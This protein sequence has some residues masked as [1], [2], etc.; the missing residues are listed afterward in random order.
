MIL[1]SDLFYRV[2]KHPTTLK[3][4]RE[5]PGGLVVRIQHFHY[6]G[7]GSIPGGGSEIPQGTQHGQ[8]KKNKK[9]KNNFKEKVKRE[10]I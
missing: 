5:F 3:E 10:Q 8:N 4:G 7:T 1:K 9:I 6:N 2:E